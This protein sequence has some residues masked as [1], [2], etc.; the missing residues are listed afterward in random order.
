LI[1]CIASVNISLPDWKAIRAM[2]E[3]TM[4]V[5]FERSSFDWIE[6]SNINMA[7]GFCGRAAEE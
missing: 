6:E 2:T 5:R 7:T 1:F 3:K 4:P